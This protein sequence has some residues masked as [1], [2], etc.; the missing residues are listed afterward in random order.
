[1]VEP[2]DSRASLPGHSSDFGAVTKRKLFSMICLTTIPVAALVTYTLANLIT[3]MNS[4]KDQSSL[5]KRIHESIVD[6]GE[7]VHRLQIERGTTALY[8]SSKG[9]DEVLLSLQEHYE[10]TDSAIN[11]I[12]NWNEMLV[13]FSDGH[14]EAFISKEA[15]RDR[16]NVYRDSVDP[17]KTHPREEIYFYTAFID[18]I[19]HWLNRDFGSYEEGQLW[20]SLVSYEMIILAKEHAGVERALGGV[21]FASGG[22]SE[23]RDFVW[24]LRQSILA[25]EFLERATA[26]SST[27][28]TL[29][30]KMLRDRCK[31]FEVLDD[32]RYRIRYNNI[33]EEPSVEMGT[34]WFLNMTD[35]I[36][37]LLTI[38]LQVADDILVILESEGARLDRYVVLSSCLLVVFL[39]LCVIIVRAVSVQTLKIH[40]YEVDLMCKTE[41]LEKEKEKTNTLLY[42]MLPVS[43]AEQL[44]TTGRVP[45]EAFDDVTIFFSD[46]VDFTRICAGSKPMQVV[47]MLNV[48][49]EC[50]DSKIEKHDVYKVETI[51]DS[52]MMVSGL[53]NRNGCRHS[54]EIANMA[55]EIRDALTEFDIPQFPGQQFRLRIGIHTGPCVAGVVGFKMPRYCLFGDTVNTASRMESTGKPSMIQ[56]SD[57]TYRAL[58]DF[59][60]FSLKR[61]GKV[62]VKGKGTMVTYWLNHKRSKTKGIKGRDAQDTGSMPESRT[63]FPLLHV[64]SEVDLLSS[65]DVQI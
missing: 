40:R 51:G 15:F 48:L 35:Y 34:W 32:M 44:K 14:T 45:A 46:I 6:A 58:L 23:Y 59:H 9:A 60:Q 18:H 42:R 61:R 11:S 24:F 63:P 12:T 41:E 13:T 43:V 62:E 21:Y 2:L 22:F 52:Y 28:D 1:M 3:G 27:I 8:I 33:T 30:N 55:L 5:T 53:P 25:Q 50:F 17:N 26:Y 57:A 38:Q 4:E 16:L 39:L 19:I 7:L 49:Y 31:L 20:R 10:K 36:D 56:I 29:Y 65:C 54:S 47:E 37:I 64:P